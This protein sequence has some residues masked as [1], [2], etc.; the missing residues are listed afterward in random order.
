MPVCSMFVGATSANVAVCSVALCGSV[1]RQRLKLSRSSCIVTVYTA[2]YLAPLWARDDSDA[3]THCCITCLCVKFW[4]Y[5]ALTDSDIPTAQLSNN[6]C[7]YLSLSRS[8]STTCAVLYC[9]LKYCCNFKLKHCG[10]LGS[11]PRQ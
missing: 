6:M 8:A 10:K 1:L 3:A 11:M 9:S 2:V 4:R 7:K 5:F